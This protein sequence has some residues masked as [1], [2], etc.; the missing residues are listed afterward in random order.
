MGVQGL[1]KLL[2]SAGKPIPVEKLENKVL[3]IGILFR[4]VRVPHLP[5]Q[6]TLIIYILKCLSLITITITSNMIYEFNITEN[7]LVL[8]FEAFKLITLFHIMFVVDFNLNFLF[9]YNNILMSN[10]NCVHVSIKYRPCYG[11]T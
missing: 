3:S 11:F 10:K 5:K 6:I 1:W 9:E 8:F 7:I 4:I 2:E